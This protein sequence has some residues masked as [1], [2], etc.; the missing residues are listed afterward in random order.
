MDKIKFTA[1]IIKV[2]TMQDGAIRLTVDLSEKDIE[3]MSRL[4]ACRIKGGVVDIIATP[5]DQSIW[6]NAE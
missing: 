4:A 1:Q 2:Q 5:K 3:T 6:G